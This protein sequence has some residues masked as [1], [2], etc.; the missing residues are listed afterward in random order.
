M[1]DSP[2]NPERRAWLL[3]AGRFLAG[4]IIAGV[5]L[6][7][8]IRKAVAMAPRVYHAGIRSLE[9]EVRINGE[10]VKAGALVKMGD[11]VSTGSKSWAIFVMGTDAFLIRDNSR[12]EFKDVMDSSR[13]IVMTHIHIAGKLL[14]VFGKGE[15][16]LITPTAAA[17][18]KG[19]GVYVEAEPDVTYLCVCYGVV[20][21]ESAS[22]PDVRETIRTTHHESP[23]YIYGQGAAKTIE[24]AKMI[25]HKDKELVMLEALVGRRP[26]FDENNE[27]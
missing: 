20:E 21:L 12:V 11:V 1:S 13:G 7:L 2:F 8:F 5:S 26:P 22:N 24:K 15:R 3:Q 6:P 16:R 9:G 18:V 23:R 14:S 19:T 4:G 27:Y 25:N 17:G 10:L